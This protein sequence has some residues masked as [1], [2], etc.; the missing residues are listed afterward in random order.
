M[1]TAEQAIVTRE[2]HGR[3]A[4]QTDMLTAVRELR[5]EG[6]SSYLS[7]PEIIV[8]LTEGKYGANGLKRRIREMAESDS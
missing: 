7:H 5:K 3:I 6:L 4:S 2:L 8:G 1:T